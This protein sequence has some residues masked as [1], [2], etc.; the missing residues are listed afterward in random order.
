[1]LLFVQTIS[2]KFWNLG[3]KRCFPFGLFIAKT[4]DQCNKLLSYRRQIA[5]SYYSKTTRAPE[6]DC[7]ATTLSHSSEG[8]LIEQWIQKYKLNLSILHNMFQIWFHLILV[9]LRP[10]S[11]ITGTLS[12]SIQNIAQFPLLLSLTKLFRG[13]PYLMWRHDKMGLLV[14]MGLIA[15]NGNM[16]ILLLTVFRLKIHPEL[17]ELWPFSGY[18]PDSPRR[19]GQ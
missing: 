5:K 6:T 11:G 14:Q 19:Y 10:W 3:Q 16:N 13:S 12:F 9:C 15:N 17:F 8:K 4:D 7:A 2:K 18:F 1:M